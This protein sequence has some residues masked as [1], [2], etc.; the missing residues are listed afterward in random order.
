[1]PYQGHGTNHPQNGILLRTDIHTLFDLGL[2]AVDAETMTVI[3][4][5]ALE[6]SDYA[7]LAGVRLRQPRDLGVAPSKAAL[8]RQRE[9][10]GLTRD[11]C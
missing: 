5:K 8:D 9:K 2:L 10:A 4:A 3:T 7:S 11:W 1:M 6:G